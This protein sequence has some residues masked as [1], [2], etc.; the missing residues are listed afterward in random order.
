MT[1][2]ASQVLLLYRKIIKEALK[3]PTQNRRDWVRNKARYEF[4]T[5]KNVNDPEQIQFLITLGETHLESLQ[6]QAAHLQKYLQWE[7]LKKFTSI[8]YTN[9]K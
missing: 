9:P 4:K 3:L 8:K 1:A 2:H 6:V 7:P 5:N